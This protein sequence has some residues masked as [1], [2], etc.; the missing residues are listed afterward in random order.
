M[1]EVFMFLA[2][3]LKVY[4]VLPEI[5]GKNFC[6]Q[7]DDQKNLVQNDARVRW[8]ENVLEVRVLLLS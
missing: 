7:M 2:S 1:A 5:F 3:C 4:V 8:V 6:G